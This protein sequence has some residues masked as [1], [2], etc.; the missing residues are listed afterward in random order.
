MFRKHSSRQAILAGTASFAIPQIKNLKGNDDFSRP[1]SAAS[2]LTTGRTVNTAGTTSRLSFEGFC[3]LLVYL[4]ARRARSSPE[5]L[6]DNPFLSERARAFIEEITPRAQ[7]LTPIVVQ[8]KSFIG[9][10][11]GVAPRGMTSSQ[12][13]QHLNCP[14]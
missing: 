11:H 7:R 5:A 4:G 1:S 9:A 3:A 6:F 14:S 10:G 13:L 8:K 12:V 2:M